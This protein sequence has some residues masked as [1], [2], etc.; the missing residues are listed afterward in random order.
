[1][2]P[3]TF[4]DDSVTALRLKLAKAEKELERMGESWAEQYNALAVART[5]LD[6]VRKDAERLD[7]LDKQLFMRV[8]NLHPRGIYANR[9]WCV[10]SPAASER[11]AD[12]GT[13]IRDAI[14]TAIAREAGK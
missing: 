8:D 9:A 3:E 2:K 4:A 1:M 12:C 6:E 7:W 11:E 14:D 5:E 13:S 10:Y